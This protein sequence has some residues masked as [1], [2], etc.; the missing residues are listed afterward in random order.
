MLSPAVLVAQ[1]DNEPQLIPYQFA[2]Y[3]AEHYGCAVVTGP[4][5]ESADPENNDD[6]GKAVLFCPEIGAHLL[7]RLPFLLEQA[8]LAV[9]TARRDEES[10]GGIRRTW[11]EAGLEV[12]FH[13][14]C[15]TASSDDRQRTILSVVRRP[16]AMEAPSTFRVVGLAGAYNEED[17][18]ESFLEHTIAQGLE[19]IL[20]DN[21]STD[22]T[23]A[24]AA[25]F[26]GRGL[27]RIEK[28]PPEGPTATH[29]WHRMLQ[30]K[31]A[32]ARETDANW[33]VH[34]DPDEIRESP[35][36]EVPMREA[37]Y[38]A[39]MDGFNAINHICA[40]FPPVGDGYRDDQPLAGQFRSF[41][42]PTFPAYFLQIRAWKRQEGEFECA[43][44][45]GHDAT[46]PGRRISPFKFLLRHYPIRSQEHG[47]RKVFGER[48]PRFSPALRARGWHVHYDGMHPLDHS[49]L[50]DPATLRS[51][52]P[53][54]FYQDYLVE[55]LSG[56]GIVT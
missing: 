48:L 24:R 27:I 38:R 8:P 21:W 49:F 56:L 39:E 19:V 54:T 26:L 14:F 30:R 2:A 4:R 29:E 36:P 23:A 1:C 50:H 9:L 18:I 16:R 25:A 43:E 52:D 46:F 33:F 37:L 34:L 45:G 6:F 20:L 3:L 22:K 5:L 51:F 17:V 12:M 10:L 44:S 41:H 47:M 15:G 40:T 42:F 55:R 53:E 11:E 32:L 7:A 31:E 13:G 35:W 28:F